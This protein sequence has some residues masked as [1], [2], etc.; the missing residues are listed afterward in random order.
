MLS[1][2]VPSFLS[3]VPVLLEF[4]AQLRLLKYISDFILSVNRN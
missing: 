3:L 1:T 4:K 2:S